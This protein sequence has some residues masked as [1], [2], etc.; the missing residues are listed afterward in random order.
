MK[1]YTY[2]IERV[3]KKGAISYRAGDTD[4]IERRV[5]EHLHGYVKSTK[6]YVIKRVI[7]A[8]T[9]KGAVTQYIV[10]NKLTTKQKKDLFDFAEEGGVRWHLYCSF[11]EPCKGTGA[12]KCG[13]ASPKFHPEYGLPP[14]KPGDFW[15]LKCEGKG[16]VYYP[17]LKRQS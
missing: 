2:L 14:N 6:G 10:Q 3:S 11:C 7:H 17:I 13:Y 1:I 9:E 16:H 15:C 4:D 8:F 5:K 12:G